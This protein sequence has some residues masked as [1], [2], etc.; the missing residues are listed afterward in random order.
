MFQ[1][2]EGKDYIF[3][4]VAIFYLFFMLVSLICHWSTY[5]LSSWCLDW[6]SAVSESEWF[7]FFH[8]GACEWLVCVC[9]DHPWV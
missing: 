4:N 2:F 5:P 8:H 3:K 6:N 7:V 1:N 9:L